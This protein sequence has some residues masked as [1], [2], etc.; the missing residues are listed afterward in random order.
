MPRYQ[1]V[2][3]DGTIIVYGW[4]KFLG[5]FC[6]ARQGRRKAL[7]Y[8][9]L[10]D[11]YQGLP[12]L[13]RELVVAKVFTQDQVEAGLTAVLQIRC[14]DEIEDDHVRA[15]ATIVHQLKQAAGE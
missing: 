3:P 15:I 13:L 8:D 11:G 1:I 9:A 5:F 10:T 12:G 6:E 14:T 4:D 2:L 7:D